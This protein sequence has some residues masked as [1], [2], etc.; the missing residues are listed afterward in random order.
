[1]VVATFVIS[2]LVLVAAAGFTLYAG[3]L[4]RIERERERARRQPKLSA[5]YEDYGGPPYLE[6]TNDGNEDLIDL[7]IELRKPL[8]G[9]I[10]P[11]TSLQEEDGRAADRINL[12]GIMA[13]ET[14]RVR[15]SRDNPEEQYGEAV[16]YANCVAADGTTWRVTVKADIPEV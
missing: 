1:V 10:A 5:F 3:R 11:I 14:K 2:I 8:I 15:V 16:L 4:W 7:V 13:A 12:G 6:I 9:Y